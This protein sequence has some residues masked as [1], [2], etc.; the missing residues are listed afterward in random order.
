M[1]E[2]MDGFETFHRLEYEPT[3]KAA[4]VLL[5]SVAEAQSAT[6]DAFAVVYER[7]NDAGAADSDSGVDAHEALLRGA[8][9]RRATALERRRKVIDARPPDATATYATLGAHSPV[10]DLVGL[11]MERRVA[12][13]LAHRPRDEESDAPLP[14]GVDPVLARDLAARAGGVTA[15]ADGLDRVRRR[16]ARRRHRR[17]GV[18]LAVVVVAV[19]LLGVGVGT[20]DRGNDDDGGAGGPP[21]H[22]VEALPLL[23]PGAG[24]VWQLVATV[25]GKSYDLVVDTTGDGVDD[26]TLE[27]RRVPPTA[28]DQNRTLDVDVVLA[29]ATA[30]AIDRSGIVPRIVWFPGGDVRAELTTISAPPAS[31]SPS[32]AAPATLAVDELIDI[33][34]DLRPGDAAEWAA[35]VADRRPDLV[36]LAL[37]GS[38]AVESARWTSGSG[39]WDPARLGGSALLWTRSIPWGQLVL[40]FTAPTGTDMDRPADAVAE[41]VSI[42][43]RDGSGQLVATTPDDAGRVRQ[44]IRWVEGPISYALSFGADVG[45]DAAMRLIGDLRIPDGDELAMLLFPTSEPS[46]VTEPHPPRRPRRSVVVVVARYLGT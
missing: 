36:P 40:T 35:G 39:G 25:P 11:P 41:G 27:V 2:A 16:V 18:R 32:T 29:G 43:V 17:R 46:D 8:L 10:D 22:P 42:P 6:D 45:V 20:I 23:T 15:P 4:F 31:T 19:V 24:A 38:T 3:L 44:E 33:V 5:G 34:R 37:A 21:T 30:V 14:P 12:V 13:V 7:W 1:A 28:F 9:A 26:A